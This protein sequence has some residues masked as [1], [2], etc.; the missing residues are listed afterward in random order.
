MYI[1]MGQMNKLRK[2][3]TQQKNVTQQKKC[4]ATI[5]MDSFSEKKTRSSFVRAEHAYR[6]AL[7]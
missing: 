4:D 7:K 1:R 5:A 3:V 2:S 6:P